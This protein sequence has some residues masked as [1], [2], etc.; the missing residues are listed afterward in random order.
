MNSKLKYLSL[1][2]I[3][4]SGLTG[5]IQPVLAQRISPGAS[6]HIEKEQSKSSRPRLILPEKIEM[7]DTE[8]RKQKYNRGALEQ[9]RA[10]S[11]AMRVKF[12]E[13]IS[14]LRSDSQEMRTRYQRKIQKLQGEINS[15]Q[16]KLERLRTDKRASDQEEDSS[17]KL[18]LPGMS[19]E[20]K[21]TKQSE[22]GTTEESGVQKQKVSENTRFNPNTASL[23]DLKSIPGLSERLAERIEWYRRE[24]QPFQKREDLSRV[25]G[26]DRQVYQQISRYFHNGPY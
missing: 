21:E 24:V 8:E 7:E 2:L 23:D 19:N 9:L 20:K 17:P 15:L 3:A 26:V 5:L 11:A 4:F 22:T 16:Q 25:P 18:E 10:D 13:K 1:I 6:A 12:E 14:E